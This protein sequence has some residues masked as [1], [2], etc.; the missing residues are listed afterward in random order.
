[1]AKRHPRLLLRPPEP[2]FL[3]TLE[4][5]ARHEVLPIVAAAA[6]RGVSRVFFVGCGGS[7]A[8]SIHA[9]TLLESLV[10]GLHTSIHTSPEFLAWPPA[11]LGERSLVIAASH[12][13]NTPETVS[14]AQRAR[15]AGALVVTLS[16][17]LHGPLASPGHYGLAYSSG[18]TITPAKQ[19]ILLR[20]ALALIAG[21]GQ[22]V[23]TSW[24]EATDRLPEALLAT[25]TA[26][27]G[28]LAETATRIAGAPFTFVL[29]TGPSRGAGYLLSMSY[30]MEMQWMLSAFFTAGEFF[31]GA[32]EMLTSDSA[33]VSF[34]GEDASRAAS[35]RA[36]TFIRAHTRRA[37]TLDSSTLAL[38][39][40]AQDARALVAPIAF[41]VLAG[42][43]T[44]H[45]EAVTGHSITERRY[46]GKGGY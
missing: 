21:Q 11:G 6:A 8:S 20:L 37:V 7:Y 19:I 35:L 28:S 22:P 46:M 43:L 39:G 36:D 45:L 25:I 10:P 14:A 17:D 23:P 31:H 33:A 24:R 4:R 18:R 41:G 26:I 5:A 29:A 16:R 27:D 32:F 40:I 30:L 34:I 12:S 38:P 3:P 9:Q 42:R 13:G 1:M 15:D 44:D 2:D